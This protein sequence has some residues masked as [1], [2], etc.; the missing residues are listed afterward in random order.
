MASGIK[1]TKEAEEKYLELQ[2]S[3]K[4]KWIVFGFSE[5]L[6]VV[7]LKAV[8]DKDAT[9]RDLRENISHEKAFFIAYHCEYNLKDGQFRKKVL[10]VLYADDNH[11]DRKQKMLS[12]STF[13]E[14]K[15]SCPE[16]AKAVTINDRTDLTED[17]FI[18]IVSDN[19][20]K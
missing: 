13:K 16:Y 5:D 2:Q 19:R 9:F 12:D 20:T 18:N 11:C 3:H 14:V 1:M 10:L 4:Y 17:N 15:M 8:G 6:S 7:E